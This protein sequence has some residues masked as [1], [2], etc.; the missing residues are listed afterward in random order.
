[1]PDPIQIRILLNQHM[2]AMIDGYMPGDP[3][4]EVFSDERFLPYREDAVV[5]LEY[6]FEENQWIDAN[7]RP[8]YDGARSLSKGDVVILHDKA[9]AVASMGFDLLPM[10]VDKLLAS[11]EKLCSCGHNAR[12]HSDEGCTYCDCNEFVQ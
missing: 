9:W 12:S 7:R 4:T 3:L 8:W 6:I 5:S 1:M 10:D 11:G 2:A